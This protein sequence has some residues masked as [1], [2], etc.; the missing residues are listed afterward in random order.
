MSTQELL[1]LTGQT[2]LEQLGVYSSYDLRG[3]L[4]GVVSEWEERDAFSVRTDAS[5]RLSTR[6]IAGHIITQK[7]LELAEKIEVIYPPSERFINQA[8][9]R[10]DSQIDKNH[11]AEVE[12]GIKHKELI[13]APVIGLKNASPSEFAFV[14]PGKGIVFDLE[15]KDRV[16]DI[17][18]EQ[19]Q[20]IADFI[21]WQDDRKILKTLRH[22]CLVVNDE[23]R[24]EQQAGR[25]G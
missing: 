11:T 3:E 17:I 13:V 8:E 22:I 16:D 12:F 15:E 4:A 5:A 24:R 20:S 18:T 9:Y 6:G 14:L 25:L 10:L 19:A 23:K 1:E 7:H 2:Q 21:L